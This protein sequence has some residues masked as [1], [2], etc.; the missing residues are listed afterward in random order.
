VFFEIHVAGLGTFQG[1]HWAH[2]RALS[3]ANCHVAASVLME[4]KELIK[5]HVKTKGNQ[6]NRKVSMLNCARVPLLK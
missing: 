1:L 2:A 5:K 6:V 3:V 4:P